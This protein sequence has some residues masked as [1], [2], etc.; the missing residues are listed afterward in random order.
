MR[1][2][3][4]RSALGSAHDPLPAIVRML[5]GSPKS[6]SPLRLLSTSSE[7][8]QREHAGGALGSSDIPFVDVLGRNVGAP[9]G[10]F[11][12]PLSSCQ[13]CQRLAS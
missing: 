5:Y 12:R 10:S 4:S 2:Y 8:F 7:H 3:S 9:V 11:V 13:L 1:T 6:G